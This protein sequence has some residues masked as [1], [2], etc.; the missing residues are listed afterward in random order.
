[1]SV[2]VTFDMLDRAHWRLRGGHHP[3]EQPAADDLAKRYFDENH[4]ERSALGQRVAEMFPEAA[5]AWAEE[6]EAGL[7]PTPREQT[8]DLLAASGWQRNPDVTAFPAFERD[9]LVALLPSSFSGQLL[10]VQPK[11]QG[12]EVKWSVQA[13]TGTPPELAVAIAQVAVNHQRVAERAR[14]E[15]IT[16]TL[17]SGVEVKEARLDG[18]T[19]EWMVY[20]PWLVGRYKTERGMLNAVARCEAER[21]QNPPKETP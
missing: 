15:V 20:N 5:A 11:G 4:P 17:P 19:V 13:N 8:A 10:R 21:A 14:R 3:D 7:R 9:G 2:D 12:R 1:M 16:T 6:R 18:E